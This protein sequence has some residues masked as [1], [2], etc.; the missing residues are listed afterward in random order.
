MGEGRTQE[1]AGA[2][3]DGALESQVARAQA[4]FESFA[5]AS[6]EAKTLVALVRLG[7]ATGIQLSPITGIGRPNI[8][9]TLDL[10]HQKNLVTKSPERNGVWLACDRQEIIWRLRQQEQQRAQ[11]AAGSIEELSAVLERL[12]TPQAAAASVF[13]VT[14]EVSIAFRYVQAVQGA[15]TELLVANRGPFLSELEVDPV[16]IATLARGVTARALWQ[17]EE[18]YGAETVLACALAYADAGVETRVASAL[19]LSMAVIDRTITL[20]RVPTDGRSD[21]PYVATATVD[22]A[23]FAQ[24]MAGAFEQ[25]WVTA[26]PLDPATTITTDPALSEPPFSPLGAPS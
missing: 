19:P 1:G 18:V 16:V 21:L 9:R 13:E 12:P 26:R 11:A 3:D 4:L 2:G 22:N 20:L 24:V 15:T 6:S 7:A 14:D 8:Y 5:L 23:L 25:S 17:S 10:L